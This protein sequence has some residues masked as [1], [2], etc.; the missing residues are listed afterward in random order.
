MKFSATVMASATMVALTN[1][2]GF[3]TSP[4]PRMPG[5]AMQAACGQ[6]VYYN[7]MVRLEA[8]SETAGA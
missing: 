8:D 1:A 3:I 7:Q 4:K 6:Q 2:H 5:A